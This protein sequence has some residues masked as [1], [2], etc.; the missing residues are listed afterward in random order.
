MGKINIHQARTEDNRAGTL[1]TFLAWWCH[2]METFFALLALCE[3]IP[4]VTS[5]FPSQRTVMQNFDV[6]FDLRL[7][8]RLS[9]QLRRQWF[10][11]PSGS[12]WHNCNVGYATYKL[13]ISSLP[14]YGQWCHGSWSTLIDAMAW[15][16]MAPSHNLN[17]R[18][19]IIIPRQILQWNFIQNWNIFILGKAFENVLCRMGSILHSA[20][21]MLTG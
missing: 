14:S 4:L 17:Q 15:C 12:L 21:N 11:R 18:W 10:E 19:C 20:L 2:Q 5:K 13:A 6:V 3:G 1:V 16:L 9:K 7:N 8:K